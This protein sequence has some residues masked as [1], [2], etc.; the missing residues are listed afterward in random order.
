MK[1]LLIHDEMLNCTLPIY[2][3][4]PE[5]PRVF[6]FDPHF[7]AAEGWTLKRVQFIADG[8]AEIANVRTFKGALKDVVPLIGATGVATQATPNTRIRNWIDTLNPVPLTWIDEPAFVE[9]HGK[10]TRFT[11]YWKSVES[12]WFPKS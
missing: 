4:N 6:V 1:I 3:E 8:I 2:R 5:L 9:F 7:F 10:L 12:Q 11:P